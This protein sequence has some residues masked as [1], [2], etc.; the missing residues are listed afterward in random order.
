MSDDCPIKDMPISQTEGYSKNPWYCFL[1]E[2]MFFLYALTRKRLRGHF[3]SHPV[4][5]LKI[6]LPERGWSPVFF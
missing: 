4:V 2:P 5:F 3:D 1:E 6:Y